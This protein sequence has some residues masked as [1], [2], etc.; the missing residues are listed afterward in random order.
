MGTG[1][2]DARLV[3]RHDL[4]EKLGPCHDRYAQFKRTRQ[5][6][7]ILLYGCGIY[8]QARILRDV[9]GALSAIYCAAFL[10]K[11]P[12]KVA[13]CA[14]RTRNGKSRIYEYL[15]KAAHAYAAYSD[16]MHFIRSGKIDLV[17][18]YI[19]RPIIVD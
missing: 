9:L 6:R 8:Y 1:Y 12:C 18:I 11:F 14:V 10:L 15:G 3:V 13:R 2:G 7:V 16:K 17:H 4:S 19:T 5:L